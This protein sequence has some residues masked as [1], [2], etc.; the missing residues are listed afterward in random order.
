L[1]KRTVSLMSFAAITAGLSLS[2]ALSQNGPPDPA[3]MV[4]MRVDRMNETLKLS[5]VQQ[6]QITQIYMDAQTA[7]QQV[8]SGMR[9]ANQSLAAAIKAND[10]NAMSQAANNMGT[11]Y[12]QTTVN[13]AKAEA[14]VYA[15][16]TPDQ[17]AKFQPMVGGMGGRG[18]GMGGGGGRGRGGPPQE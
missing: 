7:N 10:S 9:E 15:Q 1:N 8:M 12:A 14:A 11:L 4:Q 16:L 17:Q 5:K 6:K 18:M 2:P 3:Q 13:N